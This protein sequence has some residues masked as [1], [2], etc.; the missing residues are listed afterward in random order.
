MVWSF[1]YLSP[2][3]PPLYAL[4]S[5]F[6]YILEIPKMVYLLTCDTGLYTVMPL[7]P[8]LSAWNVL[9]H[10]LCL[11][12]HP[13]VISSKRPFEMPKDRDSA[14]PSDHQ[15]SWEHPWPWDTGMVTGTDVEPRL[16]EFKPQLTL[17]KL[18]N[19]SV[20]QFHYL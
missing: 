5:Q 8:I 18:L 7:S 19:Q 16:P 14:I 9:S 20:P 12:S 6:I 1:S 15:A 11:C 13:G 4:T 3:P 17:S 10:F 2:Q